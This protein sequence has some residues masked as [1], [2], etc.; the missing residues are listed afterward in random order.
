MYDSL[1]TLR[2]NAANARAVLSSP[3]ATDAEKT[4]ARQQ[5]EQAGDAGR[6][7]IAAAKLVAKMSS[8]PAFVRGFGSDGG[9]EYL[10]FALVGEALRAGNA[11]QWAVWDRSITE[12]LARM[13]NRDGSWSGQHCIS[14]KTFCTAAA[15]LSLMSDRASVPVAEK[16]KK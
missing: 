6:K 2:Q 15:L 1:M 14:G 9:E 10:S 16:R 3:T 12:R 7:F 11:G 8:D 4:R 5:I 13:Q